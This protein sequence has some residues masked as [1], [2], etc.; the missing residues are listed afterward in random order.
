MLGR[1]HC[2]G[3]I[4]LNDGARAG[5][6]SKIAIP[7]PSLSAAVS[8]SAIS[9]ECH[10][11]TDDAGV[12]PND[13]ASLCPDRSSVKRTIEGRVPGADH[14]AMASTGETTE[15]FSHRI[16]ARATAEEEEPDKPAQEDVVNSEDAQEE[17]K[18]EDDPEKVKSK[19][20]TGTAKPI[21]ANVK[22]ELARAA[23]MTTGTFFAGTTQMVFLV[24][25]EAIRRHRP[26]RNATTQ[27]CSCPG[28]LSLTM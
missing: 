12:V 8:A 3:F 7:D 24:L 4:D 22:K 15:R 2:N 5:A 17:V 16:R 21:D 10:T 25:A 27:I 20:L 6:E 13:E 23:S 1:K 14:A 19:D 11:T 9:A 18:S 26:T 28:T